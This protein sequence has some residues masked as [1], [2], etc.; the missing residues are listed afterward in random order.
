VGI[1]EISMAKFKAGDTVRLNSGGPLMTVKTPEMGA[2]GKF[3]LCQ[4]FDDKNNVKSDTFAQDSLEAD[5][6]KVSFT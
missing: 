1:E 5:D 6:D 4:W 2:G 3:C